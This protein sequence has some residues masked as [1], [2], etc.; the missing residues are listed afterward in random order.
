M[1]L[2]TVTVVGHHCLIVVLVH[3][4]K[5]LAGGNDGECHHWLILCRCAWLGC[6][7]YLFSINGAWGDKPIDFFIGEF[8]KMGDIK[9][10][11]SFEFVGMVTGPLIAM[12]II[13]LGVLSLGVQKG[14]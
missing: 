7:L 3:I 14:I 8:L 6:K 11:V 12:W 9:N 1:R 13:A 10:G 2:G 4:L 5:C